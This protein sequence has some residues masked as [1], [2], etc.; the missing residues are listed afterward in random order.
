MN[1]AKSLDVKVN[2]TKNPKDKFKNSTY[3][4][5]SLRSLL[6]GSSNCG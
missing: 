1:V 5:D 4:P 2:F 6:I 3:F